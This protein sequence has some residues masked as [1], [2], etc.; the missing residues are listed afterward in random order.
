VKQ[1]LINLFVN[2]IEAV[3]DQGTIRVAAASVFTSFFT[4]RMDKKN[5]GL[6]LSICLNIV[7]SHGG[8]MS[9]EGEPGG[10]TTFTVRLSCVR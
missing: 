4:T 8:V 2:S 9:F 6:G 1:Q 3:L 7:E 5:V 10:G